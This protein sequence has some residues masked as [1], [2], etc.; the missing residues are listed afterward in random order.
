MEAYRA[1]Q[2]IFGE[3][4]VQELVP[5]RDQLPKDIEWHLVGH[6]QSNKVKYIAHFVSLIHSADSLGLLM[7]IDKQG[8]KFNRVINCLLQVHIA[9]EE[10]KYGLDEQELQTLITSPNF[11]AFQN[12]RV[13]GLMGM[14]TFTDNEQQVRK[15]FR[16]L[17]EI[18]KKL[19]ATNFKDNE[20]FT[21][22]SMGMSS[23]YR[24]A[25]EEGSTLVRVGSKIFGERQYL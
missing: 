7:E 24:I 25:I 6:L 17:A 8:Q 16:Y 9:R 18:F 23:D 1:G 11:L 4:K 22:L 20:D 13:A 14:A 2:R 3:N 15:E 19:K 21:E 12:V 10:T 5:K